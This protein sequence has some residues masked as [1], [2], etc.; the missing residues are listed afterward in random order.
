M[1]EHDV[2]LPT[3]SYLEY[4]GLFSPQTV[5]ER[6]SIVHTLSYR[7]GIMIQGSESENSEI[8]VTFLVATDQRF[9][10]WWLCRK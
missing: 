3:G 9:V 2:S 1:A 7:D 6:A 5:T 4:F 10:G 8:D